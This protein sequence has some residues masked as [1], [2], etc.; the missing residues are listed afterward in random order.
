MAQGSAATLVVSDH[1]AAILSQS[2]IGNSTTAGLLVDRL[3]LAMTISFC[4]LTL[5]VL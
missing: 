1:T 2:C 4:K 5:A 3:S